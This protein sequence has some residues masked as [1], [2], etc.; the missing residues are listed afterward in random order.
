MAW[1]DDHY[2]YS[3]GTTYIDRCTYCSLRN[4]EL[5]GV[6]WDWEDGN[7]CG[8]GSCDTSWSVG[9]RAELLDTSQERAIQGEFNHVWDD[10]DIT[11]VGF[12]SSGG[13]VV[14]LS[15]SSNHEEIAYTIEEEP[16]PTEGF[17]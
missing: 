2:R 5:N 11:G 3:E 9:C 10:T 17:C 4:R 15:D 16:F 7:A 1:N 13:I 12:S 6:S 14:R 8:F